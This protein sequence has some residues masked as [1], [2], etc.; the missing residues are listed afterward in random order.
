MEDSEV[1]CLLGNGI[2]LLTNLIRLTLLL[3][4]NLIR[5]E[6]DIIGNSLEN[7]SL[8]NAMI[9]FHILLHFQLLEEHIKFDFIVVVLDTQ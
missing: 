9:Y 2:S 1:E 5:W 3:G 6:Y 4:N 8:L 7:L